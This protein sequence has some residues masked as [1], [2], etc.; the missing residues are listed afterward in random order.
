MKRNDALIFPFSSILPGKFM[1]NVNEWGS[2]CV[3]ACVCEKECVI[4]ATLAGA[5][6]GCVKV[7]RMRNQKQLSLLPFSSA[8]SGWEKRR[9]LRDIFK[10]TIAGKHATALQQQ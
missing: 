6:N 2:Y 9:K 8:A 1:R 4:S 3:R 7:A 5:Q 10:I